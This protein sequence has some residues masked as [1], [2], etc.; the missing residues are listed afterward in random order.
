M[1]SRLGFMYANFS[2]APTSRQL[3]HP[4]TAG[5]CAGAK[6]H[7]HECVLEIYVAG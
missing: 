5:C 6:D 4:A 7:P 3:S 2:D 1:E